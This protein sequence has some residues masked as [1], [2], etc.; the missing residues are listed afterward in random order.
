MK[1]I[2]RDTMHAALL[3]AEHSNST[4]RSEDTFSLIYMLMRLHPMYNSLT[5]K[6]HDAAQVLR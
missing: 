5:T 4:H 2:L 1:S 3:H 6:L